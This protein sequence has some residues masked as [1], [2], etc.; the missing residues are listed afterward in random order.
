M[1][2]VEIEITLR[3][4]KAQSF[5]CSEYG[6][7][8]H[9]PE[10][11]L[12]ENLLESTIHVQVTLYGQY[13][14]PEKSELVSSVY[15]ISC[16]V[17]LVK[18]VMLEIQHCAVIKR[19]EQA[20][21]LTFV[22]SQDPHLIQFQ[23]INGGQ[24]SSYS[25]YATISLDSFSFF[26]VVLHYLTL[27]YYKLPSVD[28]YTMVYVTPSPRTTPTQKKWEIFCCIMKFLSSVLTV[29]C[30]KY[31]LTCIHTFSSFATHRK[32]RNTV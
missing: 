22:K 1:N 10:G 3:A 32:L 31:C 4:G 19:P 15:Q 7:K 5:Q 27:G 29:S 11:A 2:P 28:Y 30:A 24:F 16:P 25:S 13:K 18:P 9:I 20:S 6:F 17:K 23:P 26:A 14:F 21:C 8:L 12:P